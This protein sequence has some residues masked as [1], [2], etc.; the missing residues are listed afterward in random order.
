MTSALRP[1]SRAPL[2][3][4]LHLWL[5]AAS[6]VATHQVA[7]AWIH[8]GIGVGLVCALVWGGAWV[9]LEDQLPVAG[10]QPSWTSLALGGTLLALGLWRTFEVFHPDA[11]VYGLPLLSGPALALL[12]VPLRQLR[13]FRDALLVL[14]LMPATLLASRVMPVEALSHLTARLTQGVLLLTGDV[15]RVDG[16]EVWLSGGGVRIAGSCSGTDMLLQVTSIAIIFVLA[17]PLRSVRTRLLMML[18][19]AP[20]AA[21]VANAVRIALLTVIVASDWSNKKWWF[22]FLHEA[23]GSLVFAALTVSGFSWLYMRR[24]ER[25]LKAVEAQ[26]G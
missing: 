7:V 14:M 2:I 18:V 13:P 15:A 5:L 1:L 3:T 19:V 10:P 24:L 4:L 23:E 22:D 11:V 26:R 25:E 20:L 21:I 6:L 17:F 9:C 16:S 8:N 12:Y